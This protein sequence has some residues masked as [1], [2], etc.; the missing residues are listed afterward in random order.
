[1]TKSILLELVMKKGLKITV[2]ESQLTARLCKNASLKI[3]GCRKISFYM[4][5]PVYYIDMNIRKR[6]L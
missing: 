3:T 6:L 2:F 4:L 5:H 1:M